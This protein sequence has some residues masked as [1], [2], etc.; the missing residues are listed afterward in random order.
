VLQNLEKTL[1]RTAGREFVRARAQKIRPQIQDLER[2]GFALD[3]QIDL[4]AAAGLGSEYEESTI[5]YKLYSA[6]TVPE[7]TLISADMEELLEAYDRYLAGR[8]TE[9]L[10]SQKRWW[11]LPG[12]SRLLR[13]RARRERSGGHDVGGEAAFGR[14]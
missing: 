14:D 10:P 13:P 8:E 7:D 9:S 3:D 2:H 5:A 12:Q 6:G 4:R 1:G 11:N